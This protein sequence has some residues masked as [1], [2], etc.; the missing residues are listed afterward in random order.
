MFKSL[1]TGLSPWA[2]SNGGLPGTGDGGGLSGAGDGG[3]LS[4]CGG[5]VEASLGSVGECFRC[6]DKEGRTLDDD[7]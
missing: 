2:S 4:N 5:V 3:G 7:G 1:T 6:C